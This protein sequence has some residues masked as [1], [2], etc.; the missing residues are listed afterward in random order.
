MSEEKMT[1]EKAKEFFNLAGHLI[2]ILLDE[3]FHSHKAESVALKALEAKGFL[4]GWDAR[5]C[6]DCHVIDDYPDITVDDL[7]RIKNEILKLQSEE[8]RNKTNYE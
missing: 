6:K 5:G 2:P 1:A 4:A 3:K 8:E 7:A